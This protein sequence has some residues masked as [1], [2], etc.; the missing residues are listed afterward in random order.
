MLLTSFRDQLISTSDN[1][2]WRSCDYY[3]IVFNDPIRLK[4]S[5]F[6][7]LLLGLQALTTES[8]RIF[9]LTVA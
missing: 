6:T 7:L 8:I 3:I 1:I 5:L 4:K 2:C 9:A